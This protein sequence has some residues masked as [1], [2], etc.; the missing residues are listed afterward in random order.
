M[1][2]AFFAVKEIVANENENVTSTKTSR[3]WVLGLRLPWY[4]NTDPDRAQKILNA[5]FAESA[6]I[7]IFAPRSPRAPRFQ[8][9]WIDGCAASFS[10]RSLGTRPR[11]YRPGLSKFATMFSA[12]SVCQSF[13]F[14]VLVLFLSIRRERERLR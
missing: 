1:L 13:S 7:E 6:E 2:Y 11:C 12:T 14:L 4:A 10:E 5:E 9:L 3:I 8:R